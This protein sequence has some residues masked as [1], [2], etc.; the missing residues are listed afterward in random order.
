M[1]SCHYRRMHLLSPRIP[2]ISHHGPPACPLPD[3]WRC[4][5]LTRLVMR[6]RAWRDQEGREHEGAIPMELP[7]LGGTRLPHLRTLSLNGF[8]LKVAVATIA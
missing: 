7:P 3:L 1:D 8:A 5:S 2:H 6:G 4:T